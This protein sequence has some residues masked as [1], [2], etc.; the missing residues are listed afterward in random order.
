MLGHAWADQSLWTEYR[1]QLEEW[2]R[3]ELHL[4]S[5]KNEKDE[6]W[7]V[8]T[9]LLPEY[10]LCCNYYLLKYFLFENLFK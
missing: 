10:P 3:F 7:S 9:Q 5:L 2:G 6:V 1:A 8:W 4:R